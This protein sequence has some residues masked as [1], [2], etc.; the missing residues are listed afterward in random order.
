M[1]LL[2]K[3]NDFRN[4]VDTVKKDAKNPFYKSK[5]A[6]L[7][8]VMGTIEPV[9]N[10]LKINYLQLIENMSLKT[11]IYDVENENDKIESITPLIIGDNDMQKLGSAITYA[12]RYSLVSIFNLE[13]EDDDG[14]STL[15]NKVLNTFQGAKIVNNNDKK[16][17]IEDIT[18]YI[19][20]RGYMNVNAKSIY[21]YCEKM[22]W[23]T[24]NQEDLT[25]KIVW[26]KLVDWFEK[27]NGG[28]NE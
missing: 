21:N 27:K 13:Q 14:N 16:P 23:T 12:R 11:I 18:S 7:E 26:T 17:S 9:L 4:K 8:A 19:M 15:S 24:K 28:K 22:N 20:E 5:Y 3:L 1:S 2:T 25:I 10:E 6:T